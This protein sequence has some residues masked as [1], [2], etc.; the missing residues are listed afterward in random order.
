MV[1]AVERLLASGKPRGTL[2]FLIT[3]DEEG[4]A[5]HGTRHVVEVLKARGI[6]PDFAI[7]GEVT[8]AEVLGD[9]ITIGR[10]GSLGCNLRV[11]GQQGHDAY[12]DKAA[13][14]IHWLEP[15][16][17]ELNT[18]VVASDKTHFKPTLFTGYYMTAGTA[19]MRRA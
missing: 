8:A 5:L 4:S 18:S 11:L 10:R 12:P 2:A 15:E 1:V 7:V 13:N 17:L 19:T 14:P 16:L 6:T 9:R 3:S